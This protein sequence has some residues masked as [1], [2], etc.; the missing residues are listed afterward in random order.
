[1]AVKSRGDFAKLRVFRT[2]SIAI[3]FSSVYANVKS[4]CN[5]ALAGGVGLNSCYIGM[6]EL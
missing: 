6:S 2:P 5:S 4:F 3:T 1:M